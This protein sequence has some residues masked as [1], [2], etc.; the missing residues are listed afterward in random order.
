MKILLTN[1]DGIF[2]PGLAAIYKTLRPLGDVTIVAPMGCRSGTSHS[3]TFAGPLTCEHVTVHG[4]AGFGV[5]GS[6]ADCVKL[7]CMELINGPVDLI[8]SGINRGANVGLNLFYSG[9]V[10]AALEAAFMHVPSVA[11][12]LALDE[13]MDFDTCARYGM[14]A[15]QHCLPLK[16]GDIMNINIPR[17]SQGKP[18]GIQVVPQSTVGFHEYYEP[19]TSDDPGM[20]FQLKGG[21]PNQDTV[22][23]D[24]MMLT[25]GY[26]TVTPLRADMT[27]HRRLSEFESRLKD[28]PIE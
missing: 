19:R 13:T 14:Q 21:Q 1:D 11:L 12:S 6:P 25:Q 24:T 26:V 10:A 28:I 27:Y 9:T 2:A 22:L 8:V 18:R 7:A 23:T 17:L 5:H 3:L 4:T 16:P 20:T 15:L